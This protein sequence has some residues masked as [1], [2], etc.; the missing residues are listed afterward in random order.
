MAWH[1]PSCQAMI[2]NVREGF[3]AVLKE[4]NSRHSDI[5]NPN[6]LARANTSLPAVW[7]IEMSRTQRWTFSLA[8]HLMNKTSVWVGTEF[9]FWIQEQEWLWITGHI[10]VC[11]TVKI[12]LKIVSCFMACSTYFWRNSEVTVWLFY[13]SK[14]SYCRLQ[15][16][17]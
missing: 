11:V 10:L 1:Q 13:L 15:T 7:C 9:N 2:P 5:I 6:T 4:T 12:V 8:S 14:L 3:A 16:V 17:C